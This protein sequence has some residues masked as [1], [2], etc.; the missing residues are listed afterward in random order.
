MADSSSQLRWW[1]RGDLDGFF[2]LFSNSLANTLTAIFLISVVAKMPNE[3]VFGS[4]VPAIVLSLAFG[5]IYFALQAYRLAKKER[6]GDVTAV[7]YGISVPHY[8][9]VTFAILLPVLATSKDPMRAW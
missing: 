6:R 8:F 3:I 2:G 4:M 9:I 1:V 7:P 5:N